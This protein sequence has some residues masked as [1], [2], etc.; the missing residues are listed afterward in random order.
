M[1]F[2][3]TLSYTL[4][5]MTPKN[6]HSGSV[7]Q[8]VLDEEN[9]WLRQLFRQENTLQKLFD[10]SENGMQQYK[11]T[12]IEASKDG[13]KAAKEALKREGAKA[14]LHPLLVGVDPT[15]C[16]QS[17][18]EK[19][20][21]VHMLQT[22]RPHQTVL[23]SGIGTGCSSGSTSRN[24]SVQRVSAGKEVLAGEAMRAFR[25]VTR[26]SLER[27]KR[28]QSEAETNNVTTEEE[29]GEEEYSDGDHYQEQD[30]VNDEGSV[31]EHGM[32]DEFDDT[33]DRDNDSKNVIQQGNVG[34]GLASSPAPRL[35]K[36]AR[37]KQKAGASDVPM[38]HG[39]LL[40]SGVGGDSITD[41][42]SGGGRAESSYGSEN[43]FH[44]SRHFM[45]YG[46]EDDKADF[47]ESAMQPLSGMR[48]AEL[49][50]RYSYLRFSM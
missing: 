15:R 16:N 3:S 12:R 20:K 42:S 50:G 1:E 11:R 39:V 32:A 38:A 31:G 22:F 28:A 24:K 34:G 45:T 25:K 49:Q 9:E 29:D 47:M 2:D 37:K 43:R 8:D 6:V 4:E 41:V 14:L 30:D 13:V 19:N 18:V 21:F 33:D 46:T 23:E 27:N 26:F 44:D 35:S 5:T 10:T 48:G 40:G 17:V 7:P 36:A